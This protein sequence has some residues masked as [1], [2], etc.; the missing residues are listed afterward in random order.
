MGN[1]SKDPH[2]PKNKLCTKIRSQIRFRQPV[3]RTN[4]HLIRLTTNH[5]ISFLCSSCKSFANLLI[6]CV[7]QTR[8]C[9]LCLV[10]DVQSHILQSMLDA[11]VRN[12]KN[13][14]KELVQS[15]VR[16][17]EQSRRTR[18]SHWKPITS[19]A[20]EQSFRNQSNIASARAFDNK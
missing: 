1:P 10:P 18:I 6:E 11:S 19:T 20:M 9:W 5:S 15:L 12:S 2:T 8:N 7:D 17:K 16:S 4:Q 13:H 14:S 3:R